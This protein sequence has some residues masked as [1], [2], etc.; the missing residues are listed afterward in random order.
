M[1]HLYTASAPGFE[2]ERKRNNSHDDEKT[3][4]KG[5]ELIRNRK[6]SPNTL[7]G[8]IR[9]ANKNRGITFGIGDNSDD[10]RDNAHNSGKRHCYSVSSGTGSTWED[11]GGISVKCSIVDVEAEVDGAGK[12]EILLV[13]LNSSVGEEEGH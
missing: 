12:A 13:V 3:M 7:G 10:R 4:E 1:R 9:C 11:L 6:L 5:L 8:Y 2:R